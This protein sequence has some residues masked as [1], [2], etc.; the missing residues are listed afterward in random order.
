MDSS[1]RMRNKLTE[2]RD[3]VRR[4]FKRLA[5]IMAERAREDEVSVQRQIAAV[6]KRISESRRYH[7]DIAYVLDV[8]LLPNNVPIW[9]PPWDISDIIVPARVKRVNPGCMNTCAELFV[10][11]PCEFRECFPYLFV[12]IRFGHTRRFCWYINSN[13]G[14]PARTTSYGRM[15][16]TRNTLEGR[17]FLVEENSPL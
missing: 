9:G 5:D 11:N 8:L 4:E 1:I 7:G 12:V 3:A 10:L 17:R 13:W 15:F 14:T 2:L 6:S 16:R